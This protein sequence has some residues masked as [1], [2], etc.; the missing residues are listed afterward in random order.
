MSIRDSLK[1]YLNFLKIVLWV[2]ISMTKVTDFFAF[3]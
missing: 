2:L 3:S 1:G